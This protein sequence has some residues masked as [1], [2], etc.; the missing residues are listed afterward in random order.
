[1]LPLNDNTFGP[2]FPFV[3]DDTNF[4]AALAGCPC[5]NGNGNNNQSTG[6]PPAGRVI[7]VPLGGG[8]SKPLATFSGLAGGIGVDGA[9][10]YWS[11]D[12]NAW[13]VP[14]AGGDVTAVAGNLTNGAQG[15]TCNGSCG[16]GQ[17]TPTELAVGGGGL[18][19]SVPSP[20]NALLEVGK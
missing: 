10:V 16:S 2:N 19:I 3:V 18:F 15:A 20:E 1:M 11:S 6:L 17:G 8:P 5:N 4:Y 13:K 12:T 9:D 14:R 7:A